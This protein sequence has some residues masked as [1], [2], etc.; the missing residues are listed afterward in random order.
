[1]ANIYIALLLRPTPFFRLVVMPERSTTLPI[2]Q[3]AGAAAGRDIIAPEQAVAGKISL[4]VYY[5]RFLLA[6]FVW[7]AAY[8]I[9][10]I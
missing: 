7:Y 4:I 1:M 5:A 3:T 2:S 8:Y 6:C 9:V 10:S